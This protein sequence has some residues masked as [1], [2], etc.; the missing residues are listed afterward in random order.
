MSFDGVEVRSSGSMGRGVFALRDF[1]KGDLV[2][3]GIVDKVIDRRGEHTF[4]I[5]GV[6]VVLEGPACLI[7]HS[8]DPNTMHVFNESGTFDFI[9]RRDIAAN[10]QITH[11]TSAYEYEVEHFSQ[12][13]L[14]GSEYCRGEVRGWKNLTKQQKESIREY[15][16]PFLRHIEDTE[17]LAD[18]SNLEIA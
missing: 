6:H 8:C 14:C 2:M 4:T 13:C 10:E 17:V 7:N 1:R 9:A 15:T 12:A 3:P 5:H 18:D 11:D 16:V